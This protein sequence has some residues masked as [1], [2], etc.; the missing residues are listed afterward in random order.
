M[1]KGQMSKDQ[2]GNQAAKGQ[3][4]NPRR[5]KSDRDD[6]QSRQGIGASAISSMIGAGSVTSATASRRRSREIGAL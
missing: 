2:K 1:S 5:R 3:D 4:E 6:E